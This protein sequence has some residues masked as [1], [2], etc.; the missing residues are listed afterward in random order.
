MAE[1]NEKME[2]R[3]FPVGELRAG[4]GDKPVIEGYAAVYNQ[5]SEPMWNFVEVIEPGFFEGALYG[6]IRSVWNHNTD[7]PLGRTLNGTLILEDDERGLAVKIDP[8]DTSWGRDALAS[9]KR[10]DVSQMSFAFSVRENGDRWVQ[11]DD[12]SYIR[13]LKRGGCEQLYEVSPVTF[14]AYP[15]TSVSVRS[16]VETLQNQRAEQPEEEE[17]QRGLEEKENVRRRHALRK[18][19]L[20]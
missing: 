18:K 12:G 15:Q 11:N 8:P 1:K 5:R 7:Y 17:A 4:D 6:D 14:P 19:R 3:S 2:V 20:I 9:V 16:M 13:F 10:G